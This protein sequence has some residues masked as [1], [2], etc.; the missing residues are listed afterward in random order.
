MKLKRH[1]MQIKLDSPH[2]AQLSIFYGKGLSATLRDLFR[3]TLLRDKDTVKI[4]CLLQ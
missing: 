3:D 1:S 4:T 2:A